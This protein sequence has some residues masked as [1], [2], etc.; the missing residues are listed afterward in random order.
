MPSPPEVGLV[1]HPPRAAT[2]ERRAT[3]AGSDTSARPTPSRAPPS[4]RRA[5]GGWGPGRG[6]A[7]GGAA[8]AR[9]AEVVPPLAAPVRER[10]RRRHA[11]G[12]RGRARREVV[13]DPV[14]PRAR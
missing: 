9:L 11:L 7:A 5:A 4:P 6:P 12:Q 13:D 14:H 8:V 2:S 1:Y 10:R 3:C